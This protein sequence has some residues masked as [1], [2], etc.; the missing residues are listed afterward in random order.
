MKKNS[1]YTLI[2]CALL[3]ALFVR[4]FLIS[5][6]KIPTDSMHP[7]FLSGDFIFASQVSYGVKFP[8]NQDVWFK[9]NPQ[10]NDLVIFKFKG[11]PMI[12]YLK[13]VTAVEGETITVDGNPQVVPVG[14]V[15]VASD[16]H[17]SSDENKEGFALVK[18]IESEAKLIWFSYS[19]ESGVR[20]NRVFMLPQPLR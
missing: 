4:T 1:H 11:K 2:F 9:A 5:V 7:T 6:Y 3:L 17:N 16:N 10:K 20:W 12:S 14:E 15:F 13:R 18:D 19:K 8:W